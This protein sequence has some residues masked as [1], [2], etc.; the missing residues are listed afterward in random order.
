MKLI[1]SVNQ[2]NI[3]NT[4]M[5]KLIISES[6]FKTLAQN[7]LN[8]QEKRTIRNTHLIKIKSDAKKK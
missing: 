4:R 6:Q 7:I 2:K 8:E 1:E 5:L 3:P